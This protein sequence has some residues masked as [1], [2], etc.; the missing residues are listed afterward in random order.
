MYKKI[1]ITGGVGFL[2]FHLANYFSN[3]GHN[4]CMADNLSRGVRDQQFLDL[5]SKRN[6]S[7]AD[8]DL[9]DL[10]ET[11]KV[12]TDFD[13]IFHL[14]AIIGVKHVTQ[15]PYEVLANN[16]RMVENVISLTRA[17]KDCSRLLFSSTSEVYAGTLRY[18]DLILPTPENTPLAVTDL[19][20]SR[21]SYMLSKIMGECLVQHSGVPFTIFRP[22]NIYGPRMGMA[23]VIPEQLKK[24]FCAQSGDTVTVF[25]PDHRRAFCFVDDAV[26][27][28][29]G[30]AFNDNC[31][32]LTLNLGVQSP[33]ISIRELVQICVEVSG[34]RLVVEECEVTPGSPERR[35][36]DMTEMKRLLG[37]EAQVC[38]AS[39]IKRTW[40]WYR[41]KVFSNHGLTAK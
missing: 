34:K 24:A 33:E 23:H 9:L 26:A 12:G 5:I 41:E 13:L 32:G 21:T 1:L 15:N 17:Q 10:K 36:P 35:A 2:G 19:A 8:V 14:A 18:F 27:M 25:S 31:E 11:L 16:T 39:G 40:D 29:E 38:L 37:V 28:L 7:F 4:V 30:M 3:V 20:E 6:L 22:H